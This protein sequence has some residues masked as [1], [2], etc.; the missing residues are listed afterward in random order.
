YLNYQVS[1]AQGRVLI[2]TPETLDAPADLYDGVPSPGFRMVGDYRTYSVTDPH[3][4][5]TLTVAETTDHRRE[6][7]GDS[8]R[9]LFWPLLLLVPLSMAGIWLAVRRTLAPVRRLGAEI[10]ARN[11]NNL[12]PID[13]S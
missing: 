12:A 9:T 2:R 10:A 3:T 11:S 4:G 1:D 13:A 6:A 8:T 5:I 7:V